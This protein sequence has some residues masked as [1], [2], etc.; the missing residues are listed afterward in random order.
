MGELIERGSLGPGPGRA[1]EAP[2]EQLEAAA[3]PEKVRVRLAEL[4]AE[5]G[6]PP[7]AAEG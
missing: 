4:K 1:L 2:H 3:A 5:L 7:D 6:A